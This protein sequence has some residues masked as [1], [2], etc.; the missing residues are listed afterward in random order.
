MNEELIAL[1]QGSFPPIGENEKAMMDHFVVQY[2]KEIS[3]D[4][5]K[6]AKI[7]GA[8]ILLDQP[9]ARPKTKKP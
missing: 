8:V 3:T 4:G 1:M 5:G 7:K 2:A 9:T 6:T